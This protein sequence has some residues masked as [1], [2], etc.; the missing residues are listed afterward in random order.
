MI[1]YIMIILPLLA[2]LFAI[3][4]FGVGVG[5]LKHNSLNQT[6]V[7]LQKNN[8]K[9]IKKVEGITKSWYVFGLGGASSQTLKENAVNNM[10]QEANL[11]DNQALINITY[12]TSFRIRWFVYTEKNITAYGTVIEFTN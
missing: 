12:T 9:V 11:E 5:S 4:F 7:L 1:I 6:E 2:V 3:A 10:F 8:Y